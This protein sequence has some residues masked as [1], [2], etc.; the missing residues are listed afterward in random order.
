MRREWI[1][2]F[3]VLLFAACFLF[4]ACISGTR[5]KHEGPTVVCL[6]DSLTTG[7]GADI[8]GIDNFDKSYP[9][10]LQSRINIPV[11]NAGVSGNTTAQGLARVRSDV[12]SYNPSIVIIELGANDLMQ[13][14]DISITRD[15]LQSIIDMVNDGSRKIYLVKFFT[16][17]IAREMMPPSQAAA[18]DNMFNTLA[19]ANN[20]ELINDIWAGVWG[21]HMS[22]HIHPNAAG[23]ERMAENYFN[24]LRP[25]LQ[26]NNLLR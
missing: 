10:F 17:A 19:A 16:E 9:A 22:D 21:I 24:V 2:F 7:H 15:N 13:G 23:Y 4:T 18:Y 1:A 25:F 6:G 20:V 8:P 5:G 26:I 11:I 14:I 3:L 12:L